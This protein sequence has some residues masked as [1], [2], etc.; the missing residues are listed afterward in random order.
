MIG[1]ATG[2]V[3]PS[4]KYTLYHPCLLPLGFYVCHTETDGYANM[5]TCQIDNETALNPDILPA[6]Q[7]LQQSIL[8]SLRQ[9]V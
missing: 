3:A 5:T 4:A 6:D 8:C 1:A 7:W 2:A 9:A